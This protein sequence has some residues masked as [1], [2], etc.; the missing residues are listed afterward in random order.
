[1]KVVINRCFGG[2]GL[3]NKAF[4]ELLKLKG[5]E[6]EKT[7]KPDAFLQHYYKKGQLGVEDAYIS[8]Y[9]YTENRADPDLISV[10]ETLGVEAN[11]DYSEL[12]IIEIPENVN[13]HIHEYDGMETV[14]EEHRS[15]R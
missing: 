12:K 1:M 5:V 14:H 10:V 9:D 6:W 8:P 3:S 7:N 2:F 15:W 11:S 4:E 13:W